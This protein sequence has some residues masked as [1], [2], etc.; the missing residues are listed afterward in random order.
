MNRTLLAFALMLSACSTPEEEI[1]P[2]GEASAT[3]FLA[4]SSSDG[5]ARVVESRPFEFPADHGSHDEYRSEWW[6]FTGNLNADS[7][8]HFGFELTFFRFSLDPQAAARE[9]GWGT[10]QA[11]MAH[12]AITDTEGEEF[13]A[14]ER[15]SREALG[16][17][18]DEAN[19]FRIWLE[20]WSV[21]A[22]GPDIPPIQL[23]AGTDR[24]GLALTLDSD[25]PPVSHGDDGVDAKG[26][27]RGNASHYYSLSR[28]DAIGTL[29]IDEVSF[30]VTGSA[31]MDR[32]WST[33]SLSSDLVGWDWFGL[34]LADGRE[35]MYYRLR[36]ENGESSPYSGGS[37]VQGNGT[38]VGLSVEDVVL[39]PLEHWTSPKSGATY[40]VSWQLSLPGE[41]MTLTVRPY[42]AGQELNLTVRY[43][44]GAVRVTGT[45]A[46]RELIGSGY[47][48]LTGY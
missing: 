36:D 45:Q 9:S 28:L 4:E 30:E 21:F 22:D 31:W 23:H 47:A 24:I 46:G 20:D 32:E 42:L 35:I 44:E 41:D 2:Q 39:T 38:R 17:A 7:G 1:A 10:N 29:R 12:L 34:Q 26:P 15:F 18:G 8:R 33:S 25:K 5:Y 40:P 11:W 27:E 14:V 48:E 19:P 3:R 37:V 16:L 43:W 6:Y 13:I